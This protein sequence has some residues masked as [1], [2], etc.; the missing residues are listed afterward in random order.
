MNLVLLT[1]H[2]SGSEPSTRSTSGGTSTQDQSGDGPDGEPVGVSELGRVS[3]V[4]D[5]VTDDDPESQVEGQS[6]HGGKEG[7]E[8]DEG[9]EDGACSAGKGDSEL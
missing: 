9:H 1:T 6:D 5:S 3:S 4:P 7:D 2:P 8:G